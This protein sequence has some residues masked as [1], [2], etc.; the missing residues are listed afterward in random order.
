LTRSCRHRTLGWSGE[1]EEWSKRGSAMPSVWKS[2]VQHDPCLRSAAASRRSVEP[3]CRGGIRRRRLSSRRWSSLDL[4]EALILKGALPDRR[5]RL[6]R[7]VL[8]GRHRSIGGEKRVWQGVPSPRLRR[9]FAA[10]RAERASGYAAPP[11]SDM[12]NRTRKM[13]T[14]M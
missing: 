9:L 7:G 11:R 5:C 13:T 3:A 12:I 10:C 2:A 1:G 4:G 14:K 6:R 8:R